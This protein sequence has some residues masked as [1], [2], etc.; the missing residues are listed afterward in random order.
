MGPVVPP[1]PPV[2]P[3]FS[4][5]LFPLQVSIYWCLNEEIGYIYGCYI[6]IFFVIYNLC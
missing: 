6:P 4:L 1:Y 2:L 3:L 5:L